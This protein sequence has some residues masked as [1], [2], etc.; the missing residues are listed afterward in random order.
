MTNSQLDIFRINLLENSLQSTPE[1]KY[2]IIFIIFRCV[3]PNEKEN[4]A[5]IAP[6]PIL[7][8]QME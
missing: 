8:H 5:L 1:I 4:T 6:P 3:I 7:C 2:D